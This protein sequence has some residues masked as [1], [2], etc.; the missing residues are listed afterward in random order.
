MKKL[1]YQKEASFIYSKAGIHT[2]LK[3]KLENTMLRQIK[4]LYN[5]M[6]KPILMEEN[7]N[8]KED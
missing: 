2:L 8:Q 4:S 1:H 3:L 7:T 5:T 6:L